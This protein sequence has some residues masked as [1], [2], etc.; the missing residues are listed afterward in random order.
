MIVD[1]VFLNSCIHLF[2]NSNSLLLYIAKNSML[3]R[4]IPILQINP[5]LFYPIHFILSHSFHSTL[6]RS[7]AFAILFASM[8]SRL[9]D[10][11]SITVFRYSNK[12]I[13]CIFM[14]LHHQLQQSMVENISAYQQFLFLAFS[15]LYRLGCLWIV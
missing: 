9:C 10:K 11:S 15:H 1:H 5:I 7:F 14:K 2:F 4:C 8:A 3:F 12:K 13:S 6:F